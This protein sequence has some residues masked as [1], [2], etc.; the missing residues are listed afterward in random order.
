MEQKLI[1][2]GVELEL[3]D[4]IPEMPSPD[5]NFGS[6]PMVQALTEFETVDG[7]VVLDQPD[8]VE[9]FRQLKLPDTVASGSPLPSWERRKRGD[10]SILIEMLGDIESS[11]GDE[12]LTGWFSKREARVSSLAQAARRP[13]AVLPFELADDFM[14]QINMI[15]PHFSEFLNSQ[16]FLSMRV[17]AAL[18][19]GDEAEARDGVRTM[20]Q[21]A[22]LAGS[23][24]LLI[25]H[26]VQV[27]MQQVAVSTIWHGLERGL[28][29]EESLASIDKDL[30]E[31]ARGHVDSFARAM[32]AEVCVMMIGA[33]DFFRNGGARKMNPAM[34]QG[35]GNEDNGFS[36]MGRSF[37]Q[38]FV[39]DGIWDHNKAFAAEAIYDHSLG[40]ALRGELEDVESDLTIKPSPRRFLAAMTMPVFSQIHYRTLHAVIET[41]LAIHSV[42][43]ERYRIARGDYPAS[44]DQLVPQFLDEVSVDL[45]AEGRPI[46]YRREG[47]R[48]LLYSYGQNRTDDGGET[49]WRNA[50]RKR[51][52]PKNG[53]WVWGFAHHEDRE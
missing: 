45:L 7:S 28:W 21:L 15:F 19:N 50:A 20:L 2:G 12:A 46:T 22:R 18:E 37:F 27:A 41:E 48:Y 6:H 17:V 31:L 33:A 40:P 16:K 30:C 14:V 13:E 47:N 8:L 52:D 1:D 42:A 43:L 23:Q 34:L 4:L 11:D 10:L 25:S 44:L 38:F 51:V 9:R 36:W 53:D 39:P 5:Q 24:P 49:V 32:N 3:A 29:S 26:L 35:L